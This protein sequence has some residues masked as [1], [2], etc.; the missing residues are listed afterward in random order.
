MSF[1]LQAWLLSFRWIRYCSTRKSFKI[2][3]GCIGT[4]FSTIIRLEL[5]PLEWIVGVAGEVWVSSGEFKVW[6]WFSRRCALNAL[7][8]PDLMC[9]HMELNT[10]YRPEIRN[11]I[12]CAA[13]CWAINY[14]Q[15]L[16][17]LSLSRSKRPYRRQRIASDQSE[18][19]LQL[20]N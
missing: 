7:N 13:F 4:S 11:R 19:R 15:N 3:D 18:F 8:R 20:P 1:E 14:G 2:S 10:E 6:T 9:N 17:N 12:L 5:Y 16:W